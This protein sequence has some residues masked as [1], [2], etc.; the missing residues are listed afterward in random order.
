MRTIDVGVGHDNDPVVPEIFVTIF[1]ACPT[2]QRL[3][4]I[5]YLLVRGQLFAAGADD[6]EDFAPQRK[7]RLTCTIACLLGG[8]TGR[9]AFD[10]KQ[11]R[12]KCA[13]LTTIGELA[14]EAEFLDRGLP[15]DFFLL[16]PLDA[17]FGTIDHPI[18]K[19]R[20]LL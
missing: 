7:H 4:E 1:G 16:P 5:A 12:S 3:D 2:P 20:C 9:V 11:F 8:A 18:E 13:T 14:G 6:I 19:L 10:D 15:I 17:L